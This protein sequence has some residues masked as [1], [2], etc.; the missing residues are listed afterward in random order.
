M[1]KHSCIPSRLLNRGILQNL[2]RTRHLRCSTSLMLSRPRFVV[3]VYEPRVS[4][5]GT[6]INRLPWTGCRSPF[7]RTGHPWSSPRMGELRDRKSSATTIS[8]LRDTIRMSKRF[9]DTMIRMCALIAC[10]KS[11]GTDKPSKS[12]RTLV[13]KHAYLKKEGSLNT[14]SKEVMSGSPEA[15]R[16]V[17]VPL[18]RTKIRQSQ[19]ASAFNRCVVK[20]LR[21]SYDSCLL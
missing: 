12:R 5:I 2:C 9:V 6:H 7:Q 10:E 21:S 20:I 11:I 15:H 14:T 8:R 19:A 18:S 13:E 16:G 17:R 1:L 3:G 4:F